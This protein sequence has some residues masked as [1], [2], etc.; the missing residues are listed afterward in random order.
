MWR[1]IFL[2]VA[3]AFA[4]ILSESPL[5]IRG[6]DLPDSSK[7]LSLPAD[8]RP[9]PGIP[10]RIGDNSAAGK[11]EGAKD[12]SDSGAF[13]WKDYQDPQGQD[14]K[15]EPLWQAGLWFIFKLLVVLGMIYL[16]FGIYRRM[17]A[18]RSSLTKG[19]IRVIESARLSGT[20]N[21]H[22][23]QVGDAILLIGS[24]GAGLLSRLAEWPA[25]KV[26]TPQGPVTFG[27]QLAAA[28]ER[29]DDFAGVVESSIKQVVLPPSEEPRSS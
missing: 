18:T 7:N 4:W 8:R 23:V 20:Q 6:Q 13:V 21:L 1:I 3:I 2:G 16:F 28:T 14:N 19:H 27:S 10:G 11:P 22:L 24:N 12:P 5:P 9:A 25:N 26:T 17:M 29:S 15:A